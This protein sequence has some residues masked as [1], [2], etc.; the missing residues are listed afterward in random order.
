MQPLLCT[1]VRTLLAHELMHRYWLILWSSDVISIRF[2]RSAINVNGFEWSLL[3]GVARSILR[4][5]L[6]PATPG[7]IEVGGVLVWS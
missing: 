2:D 5:I 1:Y 3:L 7:S 4:C 6:S